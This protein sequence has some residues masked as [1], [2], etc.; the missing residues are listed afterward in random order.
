[1]RKF[2]DVVDVTQVI[3][4]DVPEGWGGFLLDPGTE[5][6]FAPND[7][8]HFLEL[9]PGALLQMLRISEVVPRAH[10]QSRT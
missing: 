8:D 6:I 7:R 1:M 10:R 4:K 2:K 5:L 9:D 3:F